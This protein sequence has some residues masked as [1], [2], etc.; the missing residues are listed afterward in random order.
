MTSSQINDIYDTFIECKSRLERSC[1]RRNETLRNIE[2]LTKLVELSDS[3]MSFGCSGDYT[4]TKYTPE[5]YK[6]VLRGNNKRFKSMIQSAGKYHDKLIENIKTDTERLEKSFSDLQ[7]I[8]SDTTTITNIINSITI[9]PE[10]LRNIQ[11]NNAD[12]GFDILVKQ[13][14]GLEAAFGASPPVPYSSN[15]RARYTDSFDMSEHDKP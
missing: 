4:S 8:D 1:Q 9:I 5:N 7:K 14:F 13:S 2:N 15:K 6:A 3:F 12:S 10:S 11:T